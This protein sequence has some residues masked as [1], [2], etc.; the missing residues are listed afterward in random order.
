M[1]GTISGHLMP[2]NLGFMD[3]EGRDGKD[4]KSRAMEFSIF[5]SSAGP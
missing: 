1:P 4:E 5:Y 3:T 2:G